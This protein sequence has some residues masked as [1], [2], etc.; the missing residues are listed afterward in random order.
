MPKNLDPHAREEKLAKEKRKK[1]IRLVAHALILLLMLLLLWLLIRWLLG[2][3]LFGGRGTGGRG[4]GAQGAGQGQFRFVLPPGQPGEPGLPGQTQQQ[5]QPLVLVA[6]I[7]CPG[8]YSEDA[9]PSCIWINTLDLPNE[10]RIL[11]SV[12]G[13]G[14]R[15]MPAFREHVNIEPVRRLLSDVE[16][17]TYSMENSLELGDI[18]AQMGGTG[19]Y[20]VNVSGLSVELRDLIRRVIEETGYAVIKLSIDS[21]AYIGGPPR[22]ISAWR[23]PR[24]SYAYFTFAEHMP[25]PSAVSLGMFWG[26]IRSWA[27]GDPRI[28]IDRNSGDNNPAFLQIWQTQ[29]TRARFYERR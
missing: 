12:G 9:S 2:L 13:E 5:D 19:V 29:P 18:P 21:M 23:G 15:S 17:G 22:P 28:F 8:R 27:G 1:N 16:A 11:V 6:E 20:R 7:N 25:L 24:P 10:N 26:I 4:R 14:R 3:S